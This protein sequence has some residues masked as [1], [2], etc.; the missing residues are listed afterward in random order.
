MTSPID[1]TTLHIIFT[2]FYNSLLH[3][4]ILSHQHT[5]TTFTPLHD[6]TR[7]HTHHTTLRIIF[8]LFYHILIQYS[9]RFAFVLGVTTTGS[10]PNPT[11]RSLLSSTA[12]FVVEVEEGYTMRFNMLLILF[13]T[14]VRLDAL[15]GRKVAEFLSNN[16]ILLLLLSPI[17]SDFPLLSLSF[18]YS[19]ESTAAASH[20]AVMF[21][22]RRAIS[23]AL[24]VDTV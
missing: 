21:R 15:G 13:V 18:S 5:R 16:C 22:L 24:R 17:I 14:D 19:T 9:H 6:T 20:S 1:N 7:H 3:S 12:K 23:S 4:P 8:T 11:G 10:S 2:I